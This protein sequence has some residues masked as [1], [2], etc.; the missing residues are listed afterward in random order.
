MSPIKRKYRL[1]DA[2]FSRIRPLAPDSPLRTK[3]ENPAAGAAESLTAGSPAGGWRGFFTGIKGGRTVGVAFNQ[4]KATSLEQTPPSLPE[5]ALCIPLTI[6]GKTIGTIQGTG[7]ES[8]WTVQD[9][10]IIS[11]VAAQLAEHILNLRRL[12]QKEKHTHE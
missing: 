8:S 3:A 12:E 7:N 1:I 11:A 6:S 4:E 5:N 2:F 10:G 9:I